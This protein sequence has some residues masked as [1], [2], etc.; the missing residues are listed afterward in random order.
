MGTVLL[1]L[2]GLGG[3]VTEGQVELSLEMPTR[4][5][6]SPIEAEISQI[7]L[8]TYLPDARPRSETRQVGPDQGPLTM[9]R[10]D[11]GQGVRL[12]LEMRTANRRL[13][14][15]GRSPGAFDVVADQTVVVPMNMRRPFVYVSGGTG[16]ATFDSTKDAT[17]TDSYRGTIGL[18]RPA[19]VAIPANDGADVVVASAA[20][21]GG[22]LTLVST[23]D[24]VPS[25]NP[26]IPIAAPPSDAAVTPDSRWVVVG[27]DGD[28]GGLSVVDLAAA[29]EGRAET[30]FVTLGA[31]GAVSIGAR[32]EP[33]MAVALLDRARTSGCP[34]GGRNS[35]IAA[36]DLSDP[37][38]VPIV[39]EH[40]GP[41][42]DIAVSDDGNTV[43]AA[44]ACSGRLQRFSLIDDVQP[45]ELALVPNPT[46]V[47]I[48]N[49]RAWAVG[50]LPPGNGLAR[51]L[52]VVSVDLDGSGEVRVELPPAQE[53]A[54]AEDFSGE[55]GQA[56]EQTMDADDLFA[57]DI[58]VAPG[59]DH[60]ALLTSAY[61]HGAEEGSFLGQP[62]IPQMDLE[63]REYVLV[64]A[65]TTA[66]V[67]RVRT[68]CLL[69]WERDPFNPPFLDDWSC[70]QDAG[71]DVSSEAYAPQHLSILYGGR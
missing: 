66:I 7:G 53:R 34:T 3:C 16:L 30:R 61:Y 45:T 56:A 15:Y 58:A 10:V 38:A 24:H 5:E 64:N 6:L 27:H 14:G 65:S 23:T 13:V 1:A 2:S 33:P 29:R 47:A 21:A 44:D 42:H 12:A 43:V 20:G 25:A 51:R 8:V 48:E 17:V 9:G 63:A 19:L 46:A 55:P 35:R 31:V 4:I 39:L 69:D 68:Q 41:L 67:Q 11:V 54:R 71:Q 40:S 32:A 37:D 18:G 28:S 49:D 36:V 60:F 26:A 57:Y 22:E 50:T 59:A 70:V 62:I 52:I